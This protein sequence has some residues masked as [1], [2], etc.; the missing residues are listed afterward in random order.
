[1]FEMGAKVQVLKKGVFFPARA[2]KLYDLY[3][4]HNSLE[5]IDEKTRKQL[6]ERYFKRSFEEIYRDVREFYPPKE[7]ERAEQNP[8]YKMALIFRWYFGYST[9]L[10]LEGNT[11]QKVDFQVHCGPALGAFNQWV[12]GTPLENWRNRHVDEIAEKLLSETAELLNRRFY[13]LYHFKEK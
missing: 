4:L 3:R 2:N 6:Q 13:S 11:D 1:M 12:K 9:R 5:E 10:A 7:V 8:K